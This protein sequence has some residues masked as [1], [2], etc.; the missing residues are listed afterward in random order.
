MRTER[1]WVLAAFVVF[2]GCVPKHMNQRTAD[3]YEAFPADCS[4]DFIEDKSERDMAMLITLGHTTFAGVEGF[5]EETKAEL[6]ALTCDWGGTAVSI[7]GFSGADTA[8]SFTVHRERDP[9]P[10]GAELA[11]FGGYSSM[12]GVEIGVNAEGKAVLIVNENVKICEMRPLGGLKA[13]L[14]CDT[15]SQDG[16]FSEDC[17]T[18]N[19]GG[20]EFTKKEEEEEEEPTPDCDVEFVADTSSVDMSSYSLMEFFMLVP[21]DGFS[22][23][24]QPELRSRVCKAG[25]NALVMTKEIEV[26]KKKGG[27]YQ[28]LKKYE[29][30]PEG[31]ELACEGTYASEDG[32][33]TIAL[34][35]NVTTNFG[36]A[37]TEG[38]ARAMGGREVQV[39]MSGTN[40]FS[41]FSED[42]STFTLM[43]MDYQKQ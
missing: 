30:V 12:Q 35:G 18:A 31:A 38:E 11:C 26:M 19:F 13:V 22:E 39:V 7:L 16:F 34:P 27:A 32:S 33:V 23:E 3:R 24:Y 8:T 1:A 25:G 9:I 43:G 29:A 6:Q 5:D 37:V 2:T 10:E 20:M 42:C 36:G 15:N 40:M 17:G 14:L 41:V 4:V 28:I 21:S